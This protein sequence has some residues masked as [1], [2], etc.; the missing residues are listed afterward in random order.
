MKNQD[1]AATRASG[2]L[3]GVDKDIKGWALGLVLSRRRRLARAFGLQDLVG[4]EV[5][6]IRLQGENNVTGVLS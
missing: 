6:G 1:A 2:E 5:F 3:R 4:D